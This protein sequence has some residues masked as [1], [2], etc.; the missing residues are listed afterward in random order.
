MRLRSSAIFQ[1]HTIGTRHEF[2]NIGTSLIVHTGV[3]RYMKHSGGQ[4]VVLLIVG[5]LLSK[6]LISRIADQSLSCFI[7]LFDAYSSGPDTH[8]AP[9]CGTLCWEKRSIE[10]GRRQSL[11]SNVY[12]LYLKLY[13]LGYFPGLQH[14]SWNNRILLRARFFKCFKCLLRVQRSSV[15]AICRARLSTVEPG[16]FF[17]TN[18]HFPNLVEHPWFR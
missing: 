8:D 1:K 2:N 4:R 17:D 3:S 5:F 14:S 16:L 15:D 13:I 6:V 18:L 9:H 11:L 7:I 10:R 12:L